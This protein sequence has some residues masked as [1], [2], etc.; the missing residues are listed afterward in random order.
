M[1]KLLFTI[2]TFAF[3]A[4]MSAQRLALS[5]NV[6]S[7]L[8]MV[9]SVGAEMTVGNRVTIGLKA[10]GGYKPWG[11]DMK[12]VGV[13]PE[14]RYYFSG[15]PLHSFFVGMGALAGFYDI[16]FKD[17]VYDGVAMGGGITFGYVMNITKR[18]SIDFHGGCGAVAFDRK[19]YYVGDA[20]NSD[21]IIQGQNR[22]NAKGY[23]IMPTSIG[24]S[25]SYIIM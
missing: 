7:D 23:Y 3:A 8:L 21:Y 4:N 24:V 11:Q 12:M 6:A 2:L 16:T 17:K 5:T 14:W 20:Y 13:Q 15:R 22:T 1:K 18:F 9:P 25:V 10:F 19:E